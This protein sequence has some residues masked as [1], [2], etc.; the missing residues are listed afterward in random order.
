MQNDNEC[1]S[2]NGII[3]RLQEYQKKC[4]NVTIGEGL[5]E[6]S[7]ATS[8]LVRHDRIKKTN[9]S[10]RL[11]KVDNGNINDRDVI[12]EH[13]STAPA[14]DSTEEEKRLELN[15]RK[16]VGDDN[17][18]L[19]TQEESDDDFSDNPVRL[20]VLDEVTESTTRK[21]YGKIIS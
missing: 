17:K 13:V 11:L 6:Q 2:L 4:S 18:K 9:K 16:S 5:D 8:T 12:N 3:G 19:K 10:E 7:C 15:D 1:I 21:K 14:P 20:V